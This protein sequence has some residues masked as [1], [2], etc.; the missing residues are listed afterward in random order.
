MNKKIS[1]HNYGLCSC[2]FHSRRTVPSDINKNIP[3]EESGKENVKIEE[4][5]DQDLEDT[6]LL[7]QN[8]EEDIKRRQSGRS[9]GKNVTYKPAYFDGLPIEQVSML[10]VVDG[11]HIFKMTYNYD[12][13]KIQVPHFILVIIIF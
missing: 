11:D 13:K 1:N 8:N 10:D 4:D 6:L 5:L 9:M 2:Y 7:D 3:V 12:K